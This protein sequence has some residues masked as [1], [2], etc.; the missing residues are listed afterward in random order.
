MMAQLDTSRASA[1]SLLCVVAINSGSMLYRT[2]PTGSIEGGVTEEGV[3]LDATYQCLWD[4]RTPNAVLLLVMIF[5]GCADFAVVTQWV[6][7]R[8]SVGDTQICAD[9]VVL[10]SSWVS[11]TL[12][13]CLLN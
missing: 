8:S 2:P 4:W 1:A 10:V 13:F 11:W 6:R 12:T 3:P 5:Q 7:G 9:S